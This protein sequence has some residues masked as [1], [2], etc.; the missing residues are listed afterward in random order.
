MR[1]LS[2]HRQDPKI[3]PKTNTQTSNKKRQDKKG[4]GNEEATYPVELGGLEELGLLERA[5]EV[6]LV[7]GLWRPAVQLVE[8]VALEQLLV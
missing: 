7:E 2:G 4:T 3:P 5:E 6:A 1:L 8:H